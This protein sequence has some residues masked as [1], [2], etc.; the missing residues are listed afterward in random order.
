MNKL[1][2]KCEWHQL[3]K[4]AQSIASVLNAQCSWPRHTELSTD[5]EP[6]MQTTNY[7]QTTG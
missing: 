6:G 4:H 3:S 7:N 2:Q 5:T 1:K